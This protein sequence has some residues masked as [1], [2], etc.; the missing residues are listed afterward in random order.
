MSAARAYSGAAFGKCFSTAMSLW[1]GIFSRRRT[2][3]VRDAYPRRIANTL[4]VIQK[5]NTPEG[6]VWDRGMKAMAL[7]RAARRTAGQAW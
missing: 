2:T 1:S 3:A 5:T 6:S 4:L 7:V